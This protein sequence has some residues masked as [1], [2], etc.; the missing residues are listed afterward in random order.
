MMFLFF[1]TC[2]EMS[3]L[4]GGL[5]C[6]VTGEHAVHVAL[7]PPQQLVDLLRVPVGRSLDQLLRHI[8]RYMSLEE[9]LE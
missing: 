9:L 8:P 4:R 3:V 2:L 1:N 7:L 5:E 6:S